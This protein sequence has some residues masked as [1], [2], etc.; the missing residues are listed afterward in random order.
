MTSKL[1]DISTAV[2]SAIETKRDTVSAWPA[3]SH[4]SG[5]PGFIL[6]KWES[7]RTWL[8]YQA[9]EDFPE[10]GKVWVIGMASDDEKTESRGNTTKRIFPVQV[11]FQIQVTD[12]QDS[13][14]LDKLVELH[15]QFR[16]VCRLE[17]DPGQEDFSWMSTESLKDDEGTPFSFMG[18][19]QG[20]YFEA[21]FTAYYLS[22]LA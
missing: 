21:Y 7:A 1:V 6:S 18:L 11:A 9:L 20:S 15:D 16:E 2:L 3:K 14:H 4:W 13:D 22:L 12:P 10:G 17:V 5:S 8:P 19:R